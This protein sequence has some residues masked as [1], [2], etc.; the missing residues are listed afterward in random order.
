VDL[1]SLP[2]LLNENLGFF[3]ESTKAIHIP[4]ILGIDVEVKT[5]SNPASF[6]QYRK[7]SGQTYSFTRGRPDGAHD[8]LARGLTKA[9]PLEAFY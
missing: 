6:E 9:A 7:K 1:V 5:D 4:P 2:H 3:Q 8:C